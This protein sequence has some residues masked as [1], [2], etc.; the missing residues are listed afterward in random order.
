MF[1]INNLLALEDEMVRQSTVVSDRR[2]QLNNLLKVAFLIDNARSEILWKSQTLDDSEQVCQH[3]DKI[4]SDA[5]KKILAE[6]DWASDR[7]RKVAEAKGLIHTCYFT[8]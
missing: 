3:G 8:K 5:D 1:N 7:L 4:L 6:L 2:I